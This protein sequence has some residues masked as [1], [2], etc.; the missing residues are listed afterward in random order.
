[1]AYH[2]LSTARP[3]E[4][5]NPFASVWNAFVTWKDARSTRKA[6]NAL[7]DL[8][9]HDIGLERGDINSVANKTANW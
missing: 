3:A 9:L 7:T 2:V 5:S 4:F 6:L 1:M 8:E